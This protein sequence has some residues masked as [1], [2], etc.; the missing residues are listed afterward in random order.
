MRTKYQIDNL[1]Y[2]SNLYGR[3][4]EELLTNE[5][6]YEYAYDDSDEIKQESTMN[7]QELSNKYAFITP[8]Q[9]ELN[10]KQYLEPL[11]NLETLT[12]KKFLEIKSHINPIMLSKDQADKR[13]FYIFG[14][15]GMK[16]YWSNYKKAKEYLEKLQSS[17]LKAFNNNIHLVT[18][19]NKNKF[20]KEVNN[21]RVL[22]NK[23]KTALVNRVEN[24][25]KQSA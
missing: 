5:E 15:D 9:S 22:F 10:R 8:E 23:H 12:F 1:V 2:E 16:D 18:E 3:N 13:K 17:E 20:I 6:L 25:E 24:Q 21:S 7:Y 14:K 4:P 11:K 19:E